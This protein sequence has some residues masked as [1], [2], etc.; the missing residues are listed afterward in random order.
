MSE[1]S[2]GSAP[3][4]YAQDSEQKSHSVESNRLV[5]EDHCH[6]ILIKGNPANKHKK[7]L[8]ENAFFVWHSNY[9]LN[10]SEIH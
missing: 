8:E 5:S 9:L 10:F 3:Q 1:R 6:Y 2:A 7:Y 4:V